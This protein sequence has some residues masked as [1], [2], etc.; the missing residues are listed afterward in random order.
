LA[1]NPDGSRLFSASWDGTVKV[2]DVNRRREFCTITRDISAVAGLGVAFSQD[3]SRVAFSKN[4]HTVRIWDLESGKELSI[5][6]GHASRVSHLVFT[7]DGSWIASASDDGTVK[8]W[9]VRSG[10]ERWTLKAH[11]GFIETIAFN[12]NGTWLASASQDQTIK[13]WDMTIGQKL[14]TITG[15]SGTVR[16]LAFSPDGTRLASAS[17]D[18]TVKVWDVHN[19]QELRTL[20]GH[21]GPVLFVTFSPDGTRLISSGSDG[22]V[23]AWDARPMNEEILANREALCLVDFLF[24]S[25]LPRLEVMKRI[26]ADLSITEDVR[27]RAL[28][29]TNRMHEERDAKR[30]NDASRVLVR[31]R[32][33]ASDLYN[34]ALIQAETACQLEPN[35]GFYLNTLG[36]A[37]FRAGNHDKAMAM[38]LRS[39]SINQKQYHGSFPADLAF[40]AMTQHRLGRVKDAQDY[41]QRLRQRMKDPRWAKD[42]EAQDFLRETVALLAEP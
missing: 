30:F 3:G 41:L 8:V 34:Q 7:Q 10:E 5:L 2:W 28:A 15:H 14:R 36:M 23:R 22:T 4:D 33:L 12:R 13:L 38:L 9:D 25:P 6:A 11:E 18:R 39:D 32:A 1:F 37:R 19:G 29:F 16:R 42:I 17:T 26:S 35:N 31:Q 24:S 21:T 20:K 40:L 27:K